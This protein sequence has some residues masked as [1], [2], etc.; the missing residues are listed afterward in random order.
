MDIV[1]RKGK[2]KKWQ[3]MPLSYLPL[4]GCVDDELDVL[5]ELAFELLL[6]LVL[7]LEGVGR[8]LTIL[9]QAF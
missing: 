2:R 5:L 8:V 6:E 7:E 9:D 1:T 3:S 4:F